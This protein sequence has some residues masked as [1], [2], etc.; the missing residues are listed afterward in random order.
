MIETSI[1]IPTFNRLAFLKE[2]VS[3]ILE[4]TYQAFEILVVDDGSTDGTREYVRTLDGPISYLG[5]DNRGPGAARNY[6][7]RKARGKYVTF[8]DSDDLWLKDKLKVQIEFMKS[9]SEALLCYTDEIWI[10]RGVRVNQKKKHQ[11]HSGW[12]FE[13][14]LPLCIVSPSSVLMK[15]EFFQ[16]VGLFDEELPAC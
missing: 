6:G 4:Q 10:R 5:Q 2:A 8:L 13:H 11:K 1:I 15:A 14:C 3:S 12:I 9:N 16:Q 7:I